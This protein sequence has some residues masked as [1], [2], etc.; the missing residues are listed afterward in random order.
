VNSRLFID[1]CLY[2]LQVS[3]LEGEH[4]AYHAHTHIIHQAL[5]H[6]KTT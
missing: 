1:R 5:E 6:L 3:G 2:S 4:A